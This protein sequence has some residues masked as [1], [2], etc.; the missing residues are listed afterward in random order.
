MTTT[1]GWRPRRT[2]GKRYDPW[3]IE[4]E[5]TIRLRTDGHPRR[6]KTYEA[7]LRMADALNQENL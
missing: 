3:V 2:E 5:G 1:A 6:Y 7:A 4:R